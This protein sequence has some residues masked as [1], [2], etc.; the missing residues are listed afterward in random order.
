MRVFTWN[1]QN[2][3]R[4]EKLESALQ[5]FD[6]DYMRIQGTGMK[7]DNEKE[8]EMI[9]LYTVRHFGYICNPIGRNRRAGLRIAFKEKPENIIQCF[10][11]MKRKTSKEEWQL[12]DSNA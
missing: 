8:N 5:H 2:G 6:A 1:C 10:G 12:S 9:S 7:K 11:A 3:S 4:R